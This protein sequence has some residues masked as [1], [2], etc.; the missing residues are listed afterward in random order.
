MKSAKLRRCLSSVCWILGSTFAL[1]AGAQAAF[2]DPYALNNFMLVNTNADG[3]AITPDNGLSVVLTG[4]NNGSG[5]P[6]TTDLVTS[7]KAAG[8]VQFNYSYSSLDIPAQDFAGYVVGNTFTQ[9]A[10]MSGQTGMVSF[11]VPVGQTFGFRVGTVDNEFEPG[12][13]TLSNF[14][15]PVTSSGVP[16]P[17]GAQMLLLAGAVAAGYGWRCRRSGLKK[18]KCA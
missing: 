17:G 18:E 2:I 6:G 1:T 13:L 12:V 5:E 8:L 10:D 14:N 9:I 3:T 16:E 11:M 15:G 4:G 7:A